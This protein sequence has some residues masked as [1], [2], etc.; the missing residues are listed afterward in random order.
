MT[1]KISTCLGDR[2]SSRPTW[3]TFSLNEEEER[4]GEEGSRRE[5]W[6]VGTRFSDRTLAWH[7]RGPGVNPR[8]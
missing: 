4:A 1:A 6:W 5:R 7:V 2:V 8:Y 3:A